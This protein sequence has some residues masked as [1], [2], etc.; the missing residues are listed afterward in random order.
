MLISVV[1]SCNNSCPALHFGHNCSS[2]CDCGDGVQCNPVTGVCPSSMSF[3]PS[4]LPSFRPPSTDYSRS[5]HKSPHLCVCQVSEAPYSPVSWCLC[6]CCSLLCS[7]AVCVVEEP[8]LTAKTGVYLNVFFKST[9]QYNI[10]GLFAKHDKRVWKYWGYNSC[11]KFKSLIF[12]SSEIETRPLTFCSPG[13]Q[14]LTAACW[15]G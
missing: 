7:A 11:S 14:W 3:L 9:H 1:C 13:Q 12:G 10:L 8:L 6:S 15:F 5:H 2:M 4:L